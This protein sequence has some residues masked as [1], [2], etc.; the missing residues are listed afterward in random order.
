MGGAHAAG[1]AGPHE[2]GETIV[3]RFVLTRYRANGI[4]D[5]SF[6]GDG[7]VVTRFKG[8]AFASGTAARPDGKI[9]VVGG[10]GEGNS[11]TFALARYLV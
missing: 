9:V 1:C 3:W 8:G 4:L 7:K 10:A 11:E 6:G 2:C 5:P